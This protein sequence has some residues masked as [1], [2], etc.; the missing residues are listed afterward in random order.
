[1]PRSLI[2]SILF[3]LI[4]LSSQPAFTANVFD[5]A[6]SPDPQKIWPIG[7]YQKT[8]PGKTLN[9]LIEDDQW[10]ST[11]DRAPSH[12]F[13]DQAVWLRFTIKNSSDLK[14]TI[15]FFWHHA[16]IHEVDVYIVDNGQLLSRQKLGTLTPIAERPLKARMIEWTTDLPPN[17]QYDVYI[18]TASQFAISFRLKAGHSEDIENISRFYENSVYLYIGIMLAL[19][20]YNM[21]M[22]ITAKIRAH[23]YYLAYVISVTFYVI[24]LR[25]FLFQFGL[26]E[27]IIWEQRFV[28]PTVPMFLG[29]SLLFAGEF[30][31]I[32]QM[33]KFFKYGYRILLTG[34]VFLGFLSIIP[35]PHGYLAIGAPLAIATIFFTLVMS[36]YRFFQQQYY[37]AF[38][39]LGWLCML[40]GIAGHQISILVGIQSDVL[41]LAAIMI[42]TVLEATL[43][44]WALG[45]R[46][47]Q[48]KKENENLER[49]R[50]SALEHANKQLL[51]NI[52]LE[53]R[54]NIQKDNLLNTVS[55]ELKK[56]LNQIQSAIELALADNKRSISG[57]QFDSL[58]S[59]VDYLRRNV[60][61][62]ILLAEI[63]AGEIEPVIQSKPLSELISD[64]E[65]TAKDS[66]RPG[67]TWQFVNHI[68]DG[69]II[70]ID[71]RLLYI[72]IEN[73]IENSFKFSPG[74]NVRLT[75]NAITLNGIE[76]LEWALIDDGIGIDEYQIKHLFEIFYQNKNDQRETIN[77][78]GIGL[79]LVNKIAHLLGGNLKIESHLGK[80]TEVHFTHPLDGKNIN[81]SLAQLQTTSRPKVLI[82]EQ[83]PINAQLLEV[84]MQK[85]GYIT[86]VVDNGIKVIDAIKETNYQ[87][88][89]INIH[90]PV[91]SGIE[92]AI[93]VREKGYLGALFAISANDINE[94]RKKAIEAGFN[95]F[96][97]KP[98]RFK[99]LQNKIRN[100][101]S[102]QSPL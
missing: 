100:F 4:V 35:E 22:A 74:G 28:F 76:L 63:N 33:P 13:T 29:A 69:P 37:A 83:H 30:L 96:I 62:I 99:K 77:G 52:E 79:P 49:S 20:I 60:S 54:A 73:L 90:M 9:Q 48:L 98:V 66:K 21:P 91:M 92:T 8:D 14:D 97:E 65:D 40:F 89:M 7:E 43:F 12:G 15:R 24:S 10:L 71:V 87:L 1:V 55:Q 6:T 56:P 32:S 78:M 72:L 38:I 27:T 94:T 64:I 68:P 81:H 59:G 101:E 23:W 57:I 34:L 5:I 53:S 36:G 31:G 51:E 67:Q 19:V 2:A 86:R 11:V 18:R 47:N 95:D 85:L 39:F 58:T 50:L 61:N 46:V 25:G 42:A 102:L 93:M 82:A 41:A 80:G 75:L 45:Y 26:Y 17:S 3:A 44:S 88:I 70:N 84:H 16:Q